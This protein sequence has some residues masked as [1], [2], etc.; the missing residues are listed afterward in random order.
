MRGTDYDSFISPIKKVVEEQIRMMGTT[1]YSRYVF[2]L[3]IG[4]RGGGLEH[5]N[6]TRIGWRALRAALRGWPR[7]SSSTMWNVKQFGRVLGP[8]D[9]IEP[10]KTRN[11][12]FAEE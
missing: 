12:W 1:P 2:F 11:L 9:Y 8:F 4:G 5:L 7:T 3:D 10:P 6:S